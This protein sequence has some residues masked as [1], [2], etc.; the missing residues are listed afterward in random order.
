MKIN[1]LNIKSENWC[2]NLEDSEN[3][4]IYTYKNGIF[5]LENAMFIK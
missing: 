5:E 3:R 2:E 4:L 1:K